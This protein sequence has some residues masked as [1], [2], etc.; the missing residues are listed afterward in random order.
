M[1]FTINCV[2]Q[3]DDAIASKIHFK[4]KYDILDSDQRKGVWEYFLK[5]ATTPQGPLVYSKSGLESLMQKLLNDCQISSTYYLLSKIECSPSCHFQIKN[6]IFTAH[7]LAL[8]KGTQMTLS[9]LKFAIEAGENFKCDG[10]SAELTEA[11]RDY[12]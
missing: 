12:F 10:N 7:A 6:L 8:Q 1:F 3:I 5:K 11:M 2:K 4:I 9:H